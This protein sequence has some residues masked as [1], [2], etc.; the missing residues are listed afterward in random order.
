[1]LKNPARTFLATAGGLV[2]V[3]RIAAVAS[4]LAP[5]TVQALPLYA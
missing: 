4:S 3:V 2:F 1:M 5:R